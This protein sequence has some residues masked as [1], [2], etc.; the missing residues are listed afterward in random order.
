MNSS[1]LGLQNEG[2]TKLVVLAKETMNAFHH[3]PQSQW[4]LS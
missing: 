3:H 4:I 2:A 1:L